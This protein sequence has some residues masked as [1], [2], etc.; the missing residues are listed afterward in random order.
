MENCN[1]GDF[2]QHLRHISQSVHTSD[3]NDLSLDSF[4]SWHVRNMSDT[5]QALELGLFG[6]AFGQL[7]AQRLQPPFRRCSGHTDGVKG[8]LA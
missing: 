6:N 2:G 8:L 5:R 1:L 7:L 3:N 4:S